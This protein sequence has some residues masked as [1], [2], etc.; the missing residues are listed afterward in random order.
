MLSVF[1]LSFTSS[2]ARFSKNL[3]KNPKFK[4]FPKFLLSLSKV[5]KLRF[6]QNFKFNSL[7]Q[8]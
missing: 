7:L 5:I 3:R 4:V 8:Y 1:Y 2:G 6:S